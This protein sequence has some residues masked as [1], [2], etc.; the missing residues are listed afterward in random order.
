MDL[1]SLETRQ[2]TD[3]GVDAA[4]PMFSPDDA[5]I[6]FYADVDGDDDVFA[7]Y[8]DTD[9]IVPVTDNDKEDRSPTF[10]CD[11]P[12]RVIYHSDLASDDEH[13]S[14][15]ELFA[16]RIPVVGTT[17]AQPTRLTFDTEGIDIFAESDAHEERGSKEGRLPLHP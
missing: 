15:F 9:T 2:L 17:P 6:A 16:A 5:L 11:D 8:L 3:F 10:Q 1:T 13:P 4:G 7:V 12:A 14:Q